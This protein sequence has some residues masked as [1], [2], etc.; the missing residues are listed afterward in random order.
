MHL[1]GKPLAIRGNSFFDSRRRATN[2]TAKRF[3][4]SLATEQVTGFTAQVSS[5]RGP[6]PRFGEGQVE[7]LAE[8]V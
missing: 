2:I 3:C 6:K 5:R 7:K 1:Q 8:I 4:K